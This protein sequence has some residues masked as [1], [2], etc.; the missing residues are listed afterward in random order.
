[1]KIF[2]KSANIWFVSVRGNGIE[3]TAAEYAGLL[4]GTHR[5]SDDG[6]SV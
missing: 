2:I 4:A 6:K 3:I 5:I 1:M